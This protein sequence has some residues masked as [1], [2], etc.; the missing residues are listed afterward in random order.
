MTTDK[1]FPDTLLKKIYDDAA[2]ACEGQ[3]ESACWDEYA[4]CRI[5]APFDRDPLQDYTNAFITHLRRDD[6]PGQRMYPALSHR[7]RP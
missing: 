3:A 7:S 2:D 6:E 4:A 1:E 5:A